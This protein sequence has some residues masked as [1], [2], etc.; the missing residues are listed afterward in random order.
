MRDGSY[1]D[2]AA[3]WLFYICVAVMLVL[4]A[5]AMAHQRSRKRAARRAEIKAALQAEREQQ[6]PHISEQQRPANLLEEADFILVGCS[7]P[8]CVSAAIAVAQR[9]TNQRRIERQVAEFAGEVERWDGGA[10]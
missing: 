9:I 3:W 8:V 5:G 6:A 1:V 4:I 10:R 2:P 7:C